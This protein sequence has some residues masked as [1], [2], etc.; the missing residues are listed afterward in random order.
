LFV[1]FHGHTIPLQKVTD[2][3]LIKKFPTFYANG[4]FVTVLSK[5]RY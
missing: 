4:K 3:R 1:T 2:A 5:A